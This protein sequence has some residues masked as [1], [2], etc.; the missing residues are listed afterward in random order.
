MPAVSLLVIDDNPGVLELLSTALAQP[1]LEI[2]TASDPVEGLDLFCSRRPQVVITDLMMPRMSGMEVLERIVGIDPARDV[3]LMTANYS[4]NRPLRQSGTV[5]AI[6][7]TSRCRFIPLR[8]RIGRVVEEVKS[9]TVS[10]ARGRAANQLRVR[11]NRRSQPAHVGNVFAYP[12]R[13][14]ALSARADH[15]RD[16]DG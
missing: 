12:A 15:G 1:R 5:P 13:G 9:A 4:T 10:T 8:E 7:C 11:R 6:S 2:L 14:P 16:G 3:I